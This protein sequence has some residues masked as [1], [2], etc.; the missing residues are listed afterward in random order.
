MVYVPNS[1]VFDSHSSFSTSSASQEPKPSYA[2]GTYLGRPGRQHA[3]EHSCTTSRSESANSSFDDYASRLELL[4]R[5]CHFHSGLTDIASTAKAS[6]T[7]ACVEFTMDWF[8]LVAVYLAGSTATVPSPSTMIVS[9][10]SATLDTC[11]VVISIFGLVYRVAVRASPC[12]NC[13]QDRYWSR[14]VFIGPNLLRHILTIGGHGTI[15]VV[16]LQSE[17]GKPVTASIDGLSSIAQGSIFPM[18]LLIAHAIRLLIHVTIG[19]GLLDGEPIFNV[20]IDTVRLYWLQ[21]C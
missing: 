10:C 6:Q 3:N 1:T 7:F 17:V 2:Y 16:L 9:I 21:K 20:E 8:S 11:L 19:V 14:G 15:I 5:I 12:F 18:A 4:H 13:V